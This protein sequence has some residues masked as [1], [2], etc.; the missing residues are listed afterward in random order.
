MSGSTK[1]RTVLETD[2]LNDGYE[3]QIDLPEDIRKYY[4]KL[5]C[6][7]RLDKHS[8]QAKRIEEKYATV[9]QDYKLIKDDTVPV[10]VAE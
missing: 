7:G 5:Y 1:G 4:C 9:A 6:T 3:P 10:V 2:F 8:I